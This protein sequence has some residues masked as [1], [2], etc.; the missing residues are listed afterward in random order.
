[1]SLP[2]E[3]SSSSWQ[4]ASYVDATAVP[5]SSPA[6]WWR[7]GAV[8]SGLTGVSCPCCPLDLRAVV[9]PEDRVSPVQGR[10][11]RLRSHCAVQL[12]AQDVSVPG[13]TIG[14]VEDVDHDVEELHVRARPPRHMAG[15]VDVERGNRR[16]RVRPHAPVAMDD[17]DARLVF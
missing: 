6:G 1:M 12:L 2:M 17:L 7:A 15:R 14:L 5:K 4:C 9:L 11:P 16:V 3:S 13:V 8:C 10:A